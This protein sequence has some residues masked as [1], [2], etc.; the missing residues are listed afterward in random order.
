M[1]EMNFYGCETLSL[2]EVIIVSGGG[3]AYDLGHAVG[4]LGRDILIAWLFR[5]C[6][7]FCVNG[8]RIQL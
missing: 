8:N 7:K 5:H 1:K 2:N 3:V 4:S 6:P